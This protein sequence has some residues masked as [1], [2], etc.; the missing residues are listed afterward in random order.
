MIFKFLR[1]SPPPAPPAKTKSVKT[2]RKAR[3]DT[4]P[5]SPE[6]SSLQVTE[7]SAHEDWELWEN[8]VAELDSQLS[9]LQPHS[10]RFRHDADTPS[11]FQDVEAF[12]RVKNKD[13]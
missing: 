10:R 13:P 9:T 7:G 6:P 2:K 1:R 12:A 8:S 11:E 3:G 5:M 4:L